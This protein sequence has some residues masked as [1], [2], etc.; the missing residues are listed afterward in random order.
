MRLR[1]ECW[2][3]TVGDM[4]SDHFLARESE[5]WVLVPSKT[6]DSCKCLR[7]S[8]ESEPGVK[9]GVKLQD[10]ETNLVVLCL[11][12]EGVRLPLSEN[13]S[14]SEMCTG[15]LLGCTPSLSYLPTTFDFILRFLRLD[16][17]F[18]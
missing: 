17:C 6:G 16:V 10:E 8:A 7:L 12:G 13:I 5:A 11:E 15:E 2:G 3:V 14:S 4:R 9:C 18:P 1:R